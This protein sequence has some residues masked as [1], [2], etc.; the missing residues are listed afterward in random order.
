MQITVPLTFFDYWFD[1]QTTFSLN[2]K[3]F[4]YR[5]IVL[6]NLEDIGHAIRI[7]IPF[8]GGSLLINMAMN[9]HSSHDS[10]FA[11]AKDLF[12]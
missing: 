11:Q 3:H 4:K 12:G 9:I 8:T 5:S 6:L 10:G 1:I 7:D 2:L